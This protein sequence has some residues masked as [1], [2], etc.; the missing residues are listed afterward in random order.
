MVCNVF[1]RRILSFSPEDLSSLFA[2]LPSSIAVMQFK[3]VLCRNV[4]RKPPGSE[5]GNPAISKPHV[6]AQPRPIPARRRQLE[7]L[8]SQTSVTSD[9]APTSVHPESDLSI[10]RKYPRITPSDIMEL[11]STPCSSEVNVNAQELEMKAELVL[12]YGNLHKQKGSQDEDEDAEWK[13]MLQSGTLKQALDTA[14]G[15]HSI[16]EPDVTKSAQSMKKLLLLATL[17]VWGAST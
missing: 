10:A 16:V 15:E 8:Q 4:L 6:R 7:P 1:S 3:L 17:S 13:K 5:S 2:M 11:L 14:F 9:S 12:T